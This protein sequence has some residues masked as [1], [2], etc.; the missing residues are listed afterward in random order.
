MAHE[1]EGRRGYFLVVDGDGFESDFLTPENADKEA[2]RMIFDARGQRRD[3]SVVW[4]FWDEQG[5]GLKA[6]PVY[7]EVGAVAVEELA[8]VPSRPRGPKVL[9]AKGVWQLC[10]QH[11]FGMDCR[12]CVD[13]AGPRKPQL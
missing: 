8:R 4:C 11:I 2:T 12:P 3:L 13:D 9:A 1:I 6:L 10:E 5:I 7:H